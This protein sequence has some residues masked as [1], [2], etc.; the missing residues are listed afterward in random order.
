[1]LSIHAQNTVTLSSVRGAPGEEVT[2]AISLANCDAVAAMQLSIPLDESL[3]L[4]EGSATLGSRA[5]GHQ[6]TI[7]V[8]DGV[9]NVMV[10]SIS[11][12]PL[13]GV[14]GEVVSFRLKLGKEPHDFMLA[15]SKIV[16]TQSDGSPVGCSVTNG[17]V[18]IRTAKA[19]YGSMTIDYGHVPIR[20]TY[21]EMLTVTNV[22][23]EPLTV[24]GLVFSD[25]NVFSSTTDFPLTIE[26]GMSKGINITYKPVERGSVEK[27]VQVV[28]NSISKLNTIT[29]KADPFAVNELHVQGTGGVSDEEVTVYLTMNNMDDITGF[30]F[31]FD[32]PDALKYVD[33]SFMLSNRK[34]NHTVLATLN[35]RC[36]R[37][38]CYSPSNSAFTGNDGEIASFKVKLDGRYGVSLDAKK[39]CL[40]LR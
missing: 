30:Q 4:V 14:E 26:A 27:M 28:C 2:V 19:Q 35:D 37:A 1:M 23:N 40:R 13:S 24:T 3:S 12:T 20:E 10:Y 22:G 7:G 34:T 11:M 21:T 32:L 5:K 31:E 8:K 25:V 29:L 17:S 33:G 15:P 36:L 16:L 39:L 18:S 9:L 38:I 6:T